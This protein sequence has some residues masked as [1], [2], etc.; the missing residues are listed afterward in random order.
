MIY[1]T[2]HT[3]TYF[4]SKPVTVSHHAL[5]LRPRLQERQTCRTHKMEVLPVPNVSKERTD[6]FGNLVTLLITQEPHQKLMVRAVS[7]VVVTPPAPPE[8]KLAWEEAR[9]MLNADHSV[10]GIDRVQFCFDSP[11]IRTQPDFAEYAAVSFRTGHPLVEAV[12]DLTQRIHKEFQFDP[13]ATTVSSSLQEVFKGRRGVCQDFAHV[14]IACLRS[15]GLAA[16]YV[17]G[18]VE[19]TPPPNGE[20]RAAAD[21]S[22]AWL[23]V[24]CPGYG[25]LDVDPT[26]NTSLSPSHVTLAWGRDYGDVSPI[27][28]VI[29]GGG[30]HSLKVAVDVSRL[31]ESSDGGSK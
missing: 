22:H 21:A 23:S 16:R 13:K 25:W 31:D 3:T 12:I 27:R 30:D 28:G 1:R 18:Y 2:T 17:S 14:E 8:S 26:N 15:L 9:D 10:E 19:T 7:E 20:P 11:L 4:Y 6:Y 24:F 29:L 5:H